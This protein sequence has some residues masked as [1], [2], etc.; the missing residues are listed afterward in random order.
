MFAISCVGLRLEAETD[1]KLEVK[2]WICG[3]LLFFFRIVRGFARLT[4]VT[5]IS[6]RIEKL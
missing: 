1:A 3:K 2:T 4:R 5:L 6:C